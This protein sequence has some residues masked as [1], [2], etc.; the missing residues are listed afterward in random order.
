M[1]FL[2]NL[3][4]YLLVSFLLFGNAML[5]LAILWLLNLDTD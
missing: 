2:K 1:E 3:A 5:A 4:I